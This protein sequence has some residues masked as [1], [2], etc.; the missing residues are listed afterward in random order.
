MKRILAKY[1]EDNNPPSENPA[2]LKKHKERINYF[3][4]F[5]TPERGIIDCASHGIYDV[6]LPKDEDYTIAEYDLHLPKENTI[7]YKI[8]GDFTA[9]EYLFFLQIH[10]HTIDKKNK[11]DPAI[12]SLLRETPLAKLGFK[13]C[14]EFPN[15]GFFKVFLSCI[16]TDTKFSL[17]AIKVFEERRW[18]AWNTEKELPSVRFIL[19]LKRCL[20]M[21]RSNNPSTRVGKILYM[22]EICDHNFIEIMVKAKLPQNYYYTHSHIVLILIVVEPDQAKPPLLVRYLQKELH[23]KTKEDLNKNLSLV[24]KDWPLATAYLK[25]KIQ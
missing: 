9:Y 16:S 22:R 14:S 25:S 7:V 12:F 13:L 11:G 18:C 21:L 10:Q 19:A 6:I 15:A 24:E 20:H 23:A 5:E 3:F 17:A 2:P 1:L 8:K 4:V